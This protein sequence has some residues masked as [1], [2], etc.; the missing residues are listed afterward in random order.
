MNAQNIKILKMEK[1][2]FKLKTKAEKEEILKIKKIC[3]LNN[4]NSIHQWLDY[5]YERITNKKLPKE[6]E[7]KYNLVDIVNYAKEIYSFEYKIDN[8]SIVF[9]FLR[10]DKAL[11]NFLLIYNEFEGNRQKHIDIYVHKAKEF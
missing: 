3:Q 1:D 5:F 8:N 7:S 2:V 4:I 6:I 11:D 9:E 10:F